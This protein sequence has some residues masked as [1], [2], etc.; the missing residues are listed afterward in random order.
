MISLIYQ[1]GKKCIMIQAKRNPIN[2]E[3]LKILIQTIGWE[4]HTGFKADKQGAQLSQNI[5]NPAEKR[6]IED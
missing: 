4:K 2:L 3:I 5:P 6:W 1:E